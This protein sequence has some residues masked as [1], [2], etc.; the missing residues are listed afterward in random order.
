MITLIRNSLLIIIYYWRRMV[1]ILGNSVERVP[2]SDL[3]DV[4]Y[5]KQI[6]EYT[7]QEYDASTDM[8]RAISQGRLAKIDQVPAVRGTI[9][10]GN[11]SGSVSIHQ[12]GISKDDL[13]DAVREVMSESKTSGMSAHD[14]AGAFREIAPLIIDTVRQEISSKLSNVSFGGGTTVKTTSTFVGPEYIPDI[15]TDGM[16]SNVK[17]EEKQVSGDDMNSTLAALRN[18]NNK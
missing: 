5:Y 14:M 16:I 9:D 15:N 8:K 18:L 10:G 7:D 11:G 2:I 13:K 3:N 6:K 4:V 12:S 1:R 17:A